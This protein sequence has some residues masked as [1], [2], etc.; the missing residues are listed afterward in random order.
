MHVDK[1]KEYKWKQAHK[2]HDNSQLDTQPIIIFMG[3]INERSVDI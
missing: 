1:K 2:V 3:S